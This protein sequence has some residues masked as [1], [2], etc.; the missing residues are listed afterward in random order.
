MIIPSKKYSKLITNFEKYEP[1]S[2]RPKTIT[3]W[4]KAKDFYV[5]DQYGKKLIDFTSSI[6]VSNIGHSNKNL[7]NSINRTLRSPISHSYSYYNNARLKYIKKLINFIDNKKLNRCYLVSAGTEATEAALKL[8]RLNGLKKN[9]DK[10]GII[11]LKGN[12]H[13][14]TM[15][16]QMMSGNNTQSSWVGYYDKYMYNLDFPYPWSLKN[17]DIKK[18]FHKSL[19]KRF[20]KNFNFENKISGIIIEAFQGWGA[21]FYPKEYIKCLKDFCKKNKI[22]ITIDEMQSGF[23]R[24]GHKFLYEYYKLNP[25]ILCCGKGM[26][27]GFPLSGVISNEKIMNLPN[28]GDMSSTHSA[29]PLACSAGIATIEEIQKKKLVLNSKK[30]GKEL[31]LKLKSFEKKF[32]KL[33]S[34]TSSKG[35][36]A[37]IIFKN[38]K[39]KKSNVIADMICKEAYNNGLLLVNTGRES[40]KLGPPLVIDES[41]LKKALNIIELSISNTLRKL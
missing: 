14:R 15:G 8:M 28:I 9:K 37:A 2:M 39:N 3:M 38:Y 29:N 24:T 22:L 32:K 18:F 16:A 1:K 7:I 21:L 25:D 23:G 30:L 4:T 31:S 10:I 27:S 20:G 40:I 12:W 33:I 19:K 6:F 36:I 34:M 5:W 35:L 17:Q 41:N 11:T 26:G 13:G